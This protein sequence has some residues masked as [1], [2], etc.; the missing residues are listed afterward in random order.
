MKTNAARGIAGL[1][2]AV[3]LVLAVCLLAIGRLAPQTLATAQWIAVA[4]ILLSAIA[5]ATWILR[6]C[7]D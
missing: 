6:T 4:G 3:V 5:I 7:K 1:I 2:I